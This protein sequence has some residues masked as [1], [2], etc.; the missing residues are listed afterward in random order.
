MSE[1]NIVQQKESEVPSMV[2]YLRDSIAELEDVV[3]KL[4]V[5]LV[6]VMR[7]DVPH[8]A[9]EAEG[10]SMSCELSAMLSELNSK[11]IK[12]GRHVSSL[13]SRLEI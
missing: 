6:P 3:D 9:K 13:E 7:D 5:R 10:Q 11:I 12:I 4:E 8:E 2:N 1:A